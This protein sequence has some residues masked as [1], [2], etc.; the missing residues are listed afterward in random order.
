VRITLQNLNGLPALVVETGLA[1]AGFATR[2]TM[3]FELDREGRLRRLFT[4]LAPR[5]L[6]CLE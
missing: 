3:H 4:V 6:S 5:K 2:F 1:R